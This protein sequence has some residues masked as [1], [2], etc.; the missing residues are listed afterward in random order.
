MTWM[1]EQQRWTGLGAV[2]KRV[3]GG[4]LLRAF[5]LGLLTLCATASLWLFRLVNQPSAHNPTATEM[6]CATGAFLGWSLGGAFLTEG[7]GLFQLVE[8]SARYRHFTL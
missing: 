4:I 8:L 6:L 3:S 7:A 1:P 2:W 5:G